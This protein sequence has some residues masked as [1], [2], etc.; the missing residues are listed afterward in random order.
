METS[1]AL[2]STLSL[3]LRLLPRKKLSRSRKENAV[4]FLFLAICSVFMA[5]PL[6]YTIVTAFKPINE[7]FLFPP[8]F[9]VSHPTLDNF[10]A[11]NQLTQNMWVPFS[12]YLFNSVFV[13]G[14]GT[15]FYIVIASMAAFALAKYKFPGHALYFQI[16][17]WAILFRPEVTGIPQ[18]IIISKLGMVNTYFAVILPVLAGSFGV[19]LMRQFIINAIPTEMIEAARMDGATEYRIFW[20][21]VMPIVKPAW[22]TLLIFTFQ[23]FWNT[24]GVQYIYNENLK[25]LPTILQQISSAGLARAGAGSAVALVLMIPPIVIFLISQSSVMQT[26]AHS[27]LK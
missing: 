26:M 19:F 16:I 7:L 14:V 11:M 12:R 1:R 23:Q 13:A 15:A 25:M 2:R 6:V 10:I 8:R 17:V 5:L 21:V 3:K 18:Y 20:A 24:T 9:F 22:L 4:I 27:G